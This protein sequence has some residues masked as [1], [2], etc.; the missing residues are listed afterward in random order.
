MQIRKRRARKTLDDS[1][2]D[3]LIAYLVRL[4]LTVERADD[5][6]RATIVG[7]EEWLAGKYSQRDLVEAGRMIARRLTAQGKRREP[8]VEVAR[9]EPDWK[10]L[11]TGSVREAIVTSIKRFRLPNEVVDD[12]A[13]DALS[14]LCLWP[15][16]KRGEADLISGGC[17]IATNLVMDHF[18]DEPR[19]DPLPA[20]VIDAKGAA[21]GA[22]ERKLIYQQALLAGFDPWFPPHESDF[23]GHKCKLGRSPSEFIGM[24]EASTVVEC[25]DNL[26]EFWSPKELK[27]VRLRFQSTSVGEATQRRATYPRLEG[28][29]DTIVGDTLISHYFRPGVEAAEQV[30]DWYGDVLKRVKKVIG[31]RVR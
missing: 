4:G 6:A 14:R 22:R 29:Y 27:R 11:E 8:E 13:Q 26:M 3:D 25:L 9:A 30:T 28:M 21:R 10:G 31:G 1:F 23:W 12:V 19:R 20:D 15:A 16:V 17:R 18:R 24:F 5:L 7:L 2:R